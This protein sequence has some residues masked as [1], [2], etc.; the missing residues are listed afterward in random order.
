[1][2]V[3]GL[4]PKTFRR[5]DGEYDNDLSDSVQSKCIGLR[6]APKLV[7][8]FCLA[9]YTLVSPRGPHRSAFASFP[10]DPDDKDSSESDAE[11]NLEESESDQEGE[12]NES[13]QES[14]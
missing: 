3:L 2:E 7:Q 8:P 1:M 13:D 5:V 14:K 10:K 4:T 12:D 11:A 6:H 9:L